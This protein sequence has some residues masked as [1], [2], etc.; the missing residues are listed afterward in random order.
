[1]EE[2]ITNTINELE[3]MKDEHEKGAY[4]NLKLKEL[5]DQQDKLGIEINSSY[6]ILINLKKNIKNN[7]EVMKKNIELLKSR[8][9]NKK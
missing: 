2:I 7:V 4:I 1:M 3:K 8:I 5:I 9:N 6:E